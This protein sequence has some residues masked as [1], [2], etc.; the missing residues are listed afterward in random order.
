MLRSRGRPSFQAFWPPRSAAQPVWTPRKA[1]QSTSSEFLS[2]PKD[3]IPVTSLFTLRFV[4]RRRMNRTS[5]R[6]GY[7]EVPPAEH[8]LDA[9]AGPIAVLDQSGT[10]IAVNQ[11]W[12]EFGLVNSGRDVQ[13]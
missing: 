2:E 3:R 8:V 10:I 6:N 11:A 5:K 4:G 9:L 7:V 12:R 1:V 13:H